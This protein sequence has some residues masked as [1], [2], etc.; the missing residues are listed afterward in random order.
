MDVGFKERGVIVAAVPDD[1]VGLMLRLGQD[2]PV[3]DAAIDHNALVHQGLIFLP[4]FNGQPLPGKIL[5]TGEALHHLTPEV[6]IGHGMAHHHRLLSQAAQDLA[7]FPGR[8]RLAAAG[9]DGADGNHRLGGRE[10]GL[11][12]AGEQ[13]IGPGGH[14][15]GGLVHQLHMGDVTVGKDHQID[16]VVPDQGG[17]VFLRVKRDACRV[18]GTRQLRGIDAIVHQGNLGGGKGQHPVVGIILEKQ[19]EIVKI[20]A[21]RPH[22]DDFFGHSRFA[23]RLADCCRR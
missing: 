4:F 21:R 9:A 12:R 6:A 20:P 18:K 3:I 13:K 17:Q 19:V 23:P 10:H 1:D 11:G 5:E 7:D 14:H 22:D 8:R 15:L 2:L 16:P